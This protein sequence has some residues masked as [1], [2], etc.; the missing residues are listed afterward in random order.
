MISKNDYDMES[1][2]VKLSYYIFDKVLF[3]EPIIESVINSIQAGGDD[4]KISTLRNNTVENQIIKIEIQDNGLGFNLQ[5]RQNFNKIA[6]TSKKVEKC[7]GI[8]RLSYLRIFDRVFFCSNYK[9]NEKCYNVRFLFNN[10]FTKIEH[11]DDRNI[12]LTNS[13]DIGTQVIFDKITQ[14]L[15]E[16]DKKILK[17][18]SK[19]LLK[20]IISNKDHDTFSSIIFTTLAKAKD[21]SISVDSESAIIKATNIIWQ[22]DIEY[23]YGVHKINIKYAFHNFDND[24]FN[25]S[26]YIAYQ[27]GDRAVK[28]VFPVQKKFEFKDENK[29][30][31]LICF[32]KCELLDKTTNNNWKNFNLNRKEW[33][34]FNKSVQGKI[35]NEII[36]KNL[37]SDIADMQKQ[38]A[39]IENPHL[40]PI[41]ETYDKSD[42]LNGKEAVNRAIRRKEEILKDYFSSTSDNLFNEENI[43]IIQ[44]SALAELMI[45][46]FRTLENAYSICN[47]KDVLEKD[48]HN[49]LVTQRT[50]SDTVK[51]NNL[52]LLDAR[53]QYSKHIESDNSIDDVVQSIQEKDIITLFKEANLSIS[54]FEHKYNSEHNQDIKD[55]LLKRPDIAIFNEDSLVIVELKKPKLRLNDFIQKPK[56]YASLLGYKTKYKFIYCYLIG[57]EN[58]TRNDDGLNDS[59]WV[60]TIDGL[61]FFSTPQLVL[62]DANKKDITLNDVKCYYEVCNYNKFLKDCYMQHHP[63]F[64]KIGKKIEALDKYIPK[65][66]NS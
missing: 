25:D 4:I 17:C 56:L 12:K 26:D 40:K 34:D 49:V 52:W 23:E 15:S 36:F 46:R 20:H 27:V 16:N 47:N 22:Q 35:Y 48:I 3:L 41:L 43:N 57:S 13:N 61:G 28:E 30:K 64:E 19:A 29:G 59:T 5:N 2:V 60:R 53:W 65:K 66:N 55:Q 31:S 63:F 54:G 8:G 7:R 44:Q 33:N 39:I 21:I 62:E 42:F 14:N 11:K 45:S 38:Q 37:D 50:N 24:I 18:D 32:V 58:P 51:D 9:D 6:E 1:E 10:Q